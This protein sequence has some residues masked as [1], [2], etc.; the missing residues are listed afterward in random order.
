[1]NE[2][3]A[4]L[5]S[6]LNDLFFPL[7]KRR[8]RELGLTEAQEARYVSRLS[9]DLEASGSIDRVSLGTFYF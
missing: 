4:S 7:S 8:V 3:D 5:T 1:M 6:V 9:R 2:A